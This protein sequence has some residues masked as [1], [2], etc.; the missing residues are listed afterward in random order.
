MAVIESGLI[1]TFGTLIGFLWGPAV[2]WV[3][4]RVINKLFFGWTI[5][6]TLDARWFLEAGAWVIAASFL[7]GFIPARFASRTDPAEALHGF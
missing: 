3:L 2:A 1:G 7:A 6:P 5:I 4:I